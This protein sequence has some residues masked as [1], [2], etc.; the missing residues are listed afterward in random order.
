M[1]SAQAAI[2]K[3]VAAGRMTAAQVA[4]STFEAVEAGRF[5]V[6]THP[7]ILPSL[8]ARFDHVLGDGPPA[9]PYGSKPGARPAVSPG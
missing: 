8:R 3:A 9:D 2:E 5:Y 6:F 7:Q 1:R 4:R